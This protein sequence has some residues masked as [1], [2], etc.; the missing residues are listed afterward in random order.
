MTN[1]PVRRACRGLGAGGFYTGRMPHPD[2]ASRLLQL[3]H[4]A[5]ARGDAL[6]HLQLDIAQLTGQT[7]TWGSA[8]NRMMR[9]DHVG[10]FLSEVEKIGWRLEHTGYAFVQ[11]GATTSARIF[12][13]GEGQVMH[14]GVDGYFTFRAV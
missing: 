4:E 7:S 2:D 3:A 5:H 12:G 11:S 9:D 13:T 6:L 8:D 1:H 10:Y 14:G